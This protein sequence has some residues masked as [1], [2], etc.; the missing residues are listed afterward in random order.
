MLGSRTSVKWTVELTAEGGRGI[1]GWVGN[2]ILLVLPLSDNRRPAWTVASGARGSPGLGQT[3]IGSDSRQKQLRRESGHFCRQA[4]EQR[5]RARAES[6]SKKC[7][8]QRRTG[9]TSMFISS[10]TF[11]EQSQPTNTSLACTF[12]STFVQF[13]NSRG[14][15]ISAH[16]RPNRVQTGAKANDFIFGGTMRQYLDLRK[17][18]WPSWVGHV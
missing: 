7:K 10:G 15:H 13:L 9:G 16:F 3:E 18:T 8:M 11:D 14:K 5:G 12:Q 4:H 2:W 1:P 6:S 17:T